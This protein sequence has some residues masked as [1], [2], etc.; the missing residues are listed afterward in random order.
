MCAP[1]LNSL[2]SLI[3]SLAPARCMQCLGYTG[4]QCATFWAHNN[5]GMRRPQ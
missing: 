4:P 2:F 1:K 5:L 3:S